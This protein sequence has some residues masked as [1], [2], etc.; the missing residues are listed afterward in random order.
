MVEKKEAYED[1]ETPYLRW[2][3]SR[4]DAVEISVKQ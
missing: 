3:R 2:C 1:S 4:K